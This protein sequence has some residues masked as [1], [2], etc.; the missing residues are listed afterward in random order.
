[1]QQLQKTKRSRWSLIG[2]MVKE[3]LYMKLVPIN[4]MDVWLFNIFVSVLGVQGFSRGCSRVLRSS[5]YLG[6]PAMPYWGPVWCLL[7]SR[8]CGVLYM[9]WIDCSEKIVLLFI[10]SYQ[11]IT[12]L[13]CK[14]IADAILKNSTHFITLVEKNDCP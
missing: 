5:L 12:N 13:L 14:G 3:F 10:T 11:N 7:R 1:M 6:Q 8:G 2:W 9:P 4:G